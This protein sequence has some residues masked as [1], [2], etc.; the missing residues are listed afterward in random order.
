MANR[1]TATEKWVDPWFCG[2]SEKDKL[3]WIYLVDNCDHAGMWQVN[4]PLVQFHIKD[5]VFN[6]K[7]FGGRIVKLKEGK[8]FVPKFIE[9]QYKTGLN[10]ENRAHQSV[11]NILKKEGAYKGLTRGSQARNVKDKD[12]VKE[13]YGDSVLLSQ[14][15]HQSLVER[16]GE[17][18]TKSLIETMNNGIAAR[19]YKYKSHYHALLNWAKRDPG[20]I[21]PVPPKPKPD[22][23]CHICRGKGKIPEGAQKGAT[24]LCVK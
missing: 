22:K 18:Q 1:F 2:L 24:C 7:A 6:E 23:N 3:F 5:Y 15:E 12:K 20:N 9:F 13:R 16:F 8:W 21:K 10:P 17:A 11:I 4:W 14:Q 19:G